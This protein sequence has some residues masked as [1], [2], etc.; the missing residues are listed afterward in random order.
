MTEKGKTIT[1]AI[2]TLIEEYDFSVSGHQIMNAGEIIKEIRLVDPAST[3][4]FEDTIREEDMIIFT[5][6]LKSEV[7]KIYKKLLEFEVP[8]KIRILDDYMIRMYM[9][10]LK[11]PKQ[12]EEVDLNEFLNKRVILKLVIGL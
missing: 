9:A 4:I 3:V 12:F 1:D 6:Q 10:W 8:V 2:S 11:E 7:V 5:P